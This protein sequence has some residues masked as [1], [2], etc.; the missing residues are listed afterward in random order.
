MKHVRWQILLIV[1]LISLSAALYYT[2][3]RIFHDSHHIFIYLL[4]DIAF[5]PVEVLLVTIIIHQLLEKREKHSLLH[6]LNMVIGAF[7]SEAGSPLLKSL[8]S[9]DATSLKLKKELLITN[10]W[11]SKKFITMSKNLR[12]HPFAI[13][14]QKGDLGRLRIFLQEKRTFLLNLLGN[15]NLL[16]HDSFTELLWAVFH[17]SEELGQRKDITSLPA[18][19][20]AHLTGDIKRV[21]SLLLSE[22]VIYMQHL[23]KHYPY[24]FSLALRTNP[25]DDQACVEVRQ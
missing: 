4:G 7:F 17:L 5:V 12:N 19:D 20:Y 8:S 3:Y 18:T 10:N 25:F 2:H 24:L 23:K 14:I 22:W 15:P 11:N 21:Y 9:F 16:E 13:D 1:S 6:K